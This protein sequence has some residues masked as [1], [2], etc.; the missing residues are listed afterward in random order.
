M[1]LYQI[2]KEMEKRAALGRT[3]R[4]SNGDVQVLL[5]EKAL[6][7]Q[8]MLDQAVRWKEDQLEY[9]YHSAD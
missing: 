2:A 6:L 9:A 8:S 3:I 1:I 7:E 4:E 5:D